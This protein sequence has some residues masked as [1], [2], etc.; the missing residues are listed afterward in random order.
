[1]SKMSKVSTVLEL[2]MQIYLIKEFHRPIITENCN[3]KQNYDINQVL[4]SHQ[5]TEYN[6]HAVSHKR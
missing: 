6:S 2:Y 1:M 5:I 3:F 4:L